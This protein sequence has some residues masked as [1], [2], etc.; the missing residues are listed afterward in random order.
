MPSLGL[1]EG[2][3]FG[4]S[5]IHVLQAAPINVYSRRMGPGQVHDDS[6]VSAILF[7]PGEEGFT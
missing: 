1:K 3:S 2:A 6:A 4:V 5:Q 7:G